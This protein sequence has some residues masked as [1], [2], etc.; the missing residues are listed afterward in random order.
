MSVRVAIDPAFASAPRHQQGAYAIIRDEDGR[1]LLTKAAN[2]RFYLPGGRI[3]PGESAVAA[4]TR[5]LVEECGWHAAVSG[6]PWRGEQ[7]IFGGTVM[8][9]AS[10]WAATLS[11]PAGT[12]GDQILLWLSPAEAA[13]RLHRDTDRAALAA[14][15]EAKT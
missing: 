12:P 14:L 11:H 6:A 4:L 1:V 8:L 3:E 15:I 13:L 2:G 5:E 10:Y 9:S 7:E